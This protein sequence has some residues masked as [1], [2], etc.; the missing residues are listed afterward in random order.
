MAN[1]VLKVIRGISQAL[2]KN[3]DGAYEK[4]GW[5][6]FYDG[7]ERKP[8]KI[9]LKREKYDNINVDS[10]SG[11]MDGFGCHFHG[12]K[13]C[14]K[15][16][17]EVSMKDIHRNGPKKFE[18]EIEQ[19]FSDIANY[20]KKEYKKHTGESLT[21]T[22]DGEA[23]SLIQR[24]SNI[25]NWVQSTKYYK[26]G[27]ITKDI[28]DIDEPNEERSTEYRKEHGIDNA[29]R[30]FLSLSSRKNPKNVFVNKQPERP[31]LGEVDKG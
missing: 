6:D 16:H 24:M 7:D 12:N 20:I 2:S 15:Y 21:L 4:D 30:D 22:S 28:M 25:R 3:Y 11:L 13:L 19:T 14:I 27:N 18:S 1:D 5:T 8:V 26:I 31:G 17:G 10:R 9:G 29:I 23:D